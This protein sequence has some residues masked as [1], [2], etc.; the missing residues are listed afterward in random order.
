MDC[1]ITQPLLQT[2]LATAANGSFNRISI[3]GDTST[4]DT[5]LLWLTAWRATR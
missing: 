2:A 1:N 3:D 5:V 4:N